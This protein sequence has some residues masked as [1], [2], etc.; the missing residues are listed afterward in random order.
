MDNTQY[1][2]PIIPLSKDDKPGVYV[3]FGYDGCSV[4]GPYDSAV[5]ARQAA[6]VSFP[7]GRAYLLYEKNPDGQICLIG[8]Y[9][10]ERDVPAQ[11]ARP[12]GSP[13]VYHLTPE[14]MANARRSRVV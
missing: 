5:I 2:L 14:A 10:V 1:D 4:W 11:P 13:N 9:P 7:S 3:E 8:E 6:N 12:A